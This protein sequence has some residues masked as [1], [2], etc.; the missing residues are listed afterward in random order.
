ME[1]NLA[2]LALLALFY[3]FFLYATAYATNK[4]LLPEKITNHPVIYTLSLGIFASAFAYYGVIELA[5]RYGYGA[6]AY[7]L[8]AGVFFTFAPLLLKPLVEITRRFQTT[9]IADLLTLRYNSNAVGALATITMLLVSIPLLAL[10][11][12]AVAFSISIVIGKQAQGVDIAGHKVLYSDV[13]TLAYCLVVLCF[14]WAFGSNR[15]NIKGLIMAM[16]IESIVKLLGI[17]IVGIFCVYSVFGGLSGLETWLSNNPIHL[18]RLYAPLTESRSHMLV[19]VFI[20]TAV[21]MPHIF[22]L[23]MAETANKN[24]IYTV[25]WAIP[26][27]MLG[28]ALP[29]FPILWAGIKLGSSVPFE[30]FTL[31]APMLAGSTLVTIVSFLA[32]ISAATGALIVMS[33][34]VSTMLMNHLV[35]PASSFTS[36]KEI[37][38]QL[39]LMRRISIAAVILIAYLCFIILNKRYS[40]TDLVLIAFIAALQLVPAILG[41]AYWP[42][43]NRKGL[44]AGLIS[45]MSIWF[46]GLILPINSIGNSIEIAPSMSAI[47][48]GIENWNSIALWSIST[49]VILFIVVSVLTRQSAD[50]RYAAEICSDN[51]L[52]HPIRML[53]DIRDSEEMIERLSERLGE[54]MARREV[55]RAMLRLNMSASERR[56]YSLRQLR[57]EVEANLSGL[58]GIALSS[59]I[60]DSIIPLRVPESEGATDINMIEDRLNHYHDHLSGLAAELDSLRL[61]HRRT[62]EE[63]P[64][65][66]CSIGKDEE[67]LMWNVEMERLTNISSDQITGSRMSQLP[68]PWAPLLIR[69]SNS[70]NKHLYR[71]EI[72]IEQSKRWL[73]LH[74]A[75]IPSSLEHR[76]E[77]QVIL[78]ED[79]TEMQLLERE[80]L[81]NERLASVGRL[82]AG[83]AHEIGNP[84]TGI[85]C[86]AQNLKYENDDNE[87]IEAAEQILDQ[88]KRVS[89]IVH[90]LVSFSHAGRNNISEFG[91]VDLA[92]CANEAIGLLQLQKDRKQMRIENWIGKDCFVRGDEQ[93]LIQVFV[94]LLTN[95]HDA[96]EE[97]TLIRISAKGIADY[98]EL[99]VE[100][101]GPGIPKQI[102]DSILEPFFTTK[103]PGEGTGL[104]L[105]M[106]YSIVED[107]EGSI[108]VVSPSDLATQSGTKFVIKLPTPL[109]SNRT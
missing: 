93:R 38:S 57:D 61:Y 35:L 97:G 14:A 54:N 21:A 23:T 6:L 10:Q 24:A 70:E 95:A 64:L 16:A 91:S 60:M 29:I 7:Y 65:A 27:F 69:F 13:I 62:L 4:G 31:N 86:L 48:I 8:G 45:G 20:S 78:I 66:S 19:L 5:Y 92:L 3:I 33:L 28:M 2:Y 73:S 34:S 88:T 49:N 37:Y 79:T 106:V 101:Q 15:S 18:E 56:P 25:T 74:K 67:I 1:I 40:L 32:G 36:K 59:E 55:N 105:S 85:D 87:V 12:Q 103:N 26:L 96:C 82:A 108:A 42:T 81:H 80:L 44:I 99:S 17:L 30:Y 39:L 46:V 68:D 72:D 107:H 84:I 11:V 58:L 41:V 9:S 76:I 94:N 77:G 52:S 22:Q 83:V 51:E 53:L 63:L 43:G 71:E 50:E 98:V 89:R 75:A 100:D 47:K 104:G 102:Q 90:S 109:A